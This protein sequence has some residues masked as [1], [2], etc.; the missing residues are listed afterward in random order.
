MADTTPYRLDLPAQASDAEILSQVKRALR[1][2]DRSAVLILAG[3]FA[4]DVTDIKAHSDV[5]G[6]LLD[7]TIPIFAL[8]SGLIGERGLA[9]L[10]AADRIIVDHDASMTGGWRASP[11]LSP[12]L[13]QRLGSTLARTIVFDP[14]TDVLTRFVELGLAVRSSDPER[15]VQEIAATLEGGLGQRLKRSLRASSELP[16][17]EAVSFDLWF[18]R[19]RHTSAP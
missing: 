10:L 12:L 15:Y 9:L 3:S 6:L 2:A 8:P 1:E 14:S 4:G 17:K 19:P 11:G 18:S 5:I 16:L 7:A 13:H